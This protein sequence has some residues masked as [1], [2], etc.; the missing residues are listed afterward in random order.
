MKIKLQVKNI[1]SLRFKLIFNNYNTKIKIIKEPL[2]F[3]DFMV[4]FMKRPHSEMDIIFGF[5]PKVGSSNLPGGT[6]L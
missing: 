3:S 5:E 2:I 6:I 4:K 1:F